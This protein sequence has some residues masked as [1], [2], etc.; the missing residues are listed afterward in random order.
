[1]C[2]ISANGTANGIVW[3]L[4]NDASSSGGPAIL[5]AYDASNLAQEL[6]NSSQKLARDN[7][8]GAVKMT[9]PTIANGKVYV[10]AEYKLSVYGVQV[11]LDPPSISP[12]TRPCRWLKGGS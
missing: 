9:A 10:G 8:G 7:P 11:F 3:V 1:M 6:Y 12:N 4:Q 5:H 2:C